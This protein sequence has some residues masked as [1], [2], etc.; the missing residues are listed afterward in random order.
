VIK[1]DFHRS[2]FL[3][4]VANAST[5]DAYV[6]TPCVSTQRLEVAKA[7]E[8]ANIYDTTVTTRLQLNLR[9]L[10]HLVKIF[11]YLL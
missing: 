2:R 8:R 3:I 1:D 7:W 4:A 9:L 5:S 11:L 6:T 10:Y